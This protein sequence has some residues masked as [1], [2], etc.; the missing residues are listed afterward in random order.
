MPKVVL[1]I[2]AGQGTQDRQ[3]DGQTDKAAN[4]NYTSP[5]GKNKNGCLEA[6]LSFPNF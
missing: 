6:K 5:F 2:F 4:I 3:T 1:T